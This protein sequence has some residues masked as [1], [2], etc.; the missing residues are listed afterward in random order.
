MRGL[1]CPFA[2]FV[3]FVVGCSP[4]EEKAVMKEVE[5]SET[6]AQKVYRGDRQNQAT[7]QKS[8]AFWKRASVE[9]YRSPEELLAQ[10]ARERRHGLV[11]DK[12]ARGPGDKHELALTFDDGPHPDLTLKLLAL[13]KQENVK[14]TF[15]VIGKMVEKHPELLK[16]IAADGH[17]IGNHTFS[18]VTLTKI[19]VADIQVEYRANNDIVKKTIGQN[20]KF[21]RPPGGDYDSDVIHAAEACGLTTVLWTDDPGDYANPGDNVIEERTL[22]KLTNGGIILLHD[23]VKETLDVLPQIIAYAKKKGFSFVTIDE[24]S[25]K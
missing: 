5:A 14:A 16:A 22:A 6:A 24:F 7:E 15:F 17:T 10:D 21:C 11:L 9:V 8:D 20:M 23:G 3:C 1:I 13:L 25:K 12:I 2:L 18:H 4:A 19:P